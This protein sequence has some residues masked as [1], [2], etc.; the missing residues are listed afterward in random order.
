M[1]HLGLLISALLFGLVHMN[2]KA[3]DFPVFKF[4][5]YTVD[6]GLSV[7]TVTSIIQDSR[8]FM[9][10]A[11]SSGI[12]RYDGVRFRS[13]VPSCE[14]L[15]VERIDIIQSIAEAPD[16]CILAGTDFGLF[17]FN[18]E[19]ESFRRFTMTDGNGTGITSPVYDI[20]AGVEAGKDVIWVATYGQGI[21]CIDAE[22]LSAHD[23][24]SH[25]SIVRYSSQD[26]LPT[27]YVRNIHIDSKGRVWV[28][29]FGDKF[30]YL[31]P[32]RNFMTS[33]SHYAGNS[34]ARYDVMLEDG[35]DVFWLGNYT[36]GLTRFD[37]NTGEFTDFLVPGS[38]GYVSHIR[39]M[40]KYS[41]DLL[42]IASDDGLTYFD[43]RTFSYRT[44]KS[45]RGL[46]Y[47]LNDNYVHSLFIDREK[48][49][50]VGT[51]FGGVS[52][53]PSSAGNFKLFSPYSPESYIEGKIVS[54]VETDSNDNFWI[55]T[56]DA[57]VIFY[58]RKTGYR[59][60]YLPDTGKN[61]ISYHNIHAVCCTGDEVWIGTYSAGVDVLDLKTGKI[62]HYDAD[63]RPG[64]LIHSSVYAL[65]QDSDGTMWVGTS[66]GC[67]TYDGTTDSFVRIEE[68]HGADV[69]CITEDGHGYVL[70]SSYNQGLFRL[71]KN[72]GTW[73]HFTSAGGE[74][75]SDI[76][77]TVSC[78][79]DG[80]L[81]IG[82]GG[83][84]IA[85]YDPSGMKF[86][87]LDADILMDTPVHKIIEYDE[88]IWASTNKGLVKLYRKTLD[89]KL[90]D[91]SDGLQSIQFCPNSGCLTK[92]GVLLFGGINGLN[93]FRPEDLMENTVIPSVY[94]TNI[95]LFNKPLHPGDGSGILDRAPGYVDG[96]TLRHDESVLGIDFV[97]LSFSS[98]DK[99]MYLYMLEGLDDEWTPA[100]HGKSVTYANLAP[101]SY[102]FRVKASNNDML[103]NDSGASLRIRVLPAPWLSP[104]ALTAYAVIFAVSV[105]WAVRM[106]VQRIR[107]MHA[108]SLMRLKVA[109]E[110]ELYESKMSF[111]TDMIHEIRTPLTLIVG[112]LE[113]I[114]KSSRNLTEDNKDDL[115]MIGRNSERLLSLVNQ[116]L[117]YR[118]AE[119]GTMRISFSAMDLNLCVAQ[120]TEPFA[121]SARQRGIDFIVNLPSEHI[122]GEFD[123]DVMSKI[124]SNL[125]SNAMKFTSDKVILDIAS[126][127]AGDDGRRLCIRCD[128]NG[129]GIP[130]A[131]RE[132]IFDSFYQIRSNQPKD[133]VGSGLGLSLVKSIVSCLGG[134]VTVGTAAIGG[135]SFRVSFPF[136]PSSSEV[137]CPSDEDVA[138]GHETAGEETEADGFLPDI[139]TVMIVDDNPDML[140]FLSS[141]LSENYG[142]LSFSN[143]DD[144]L[145]SMEDRLPDLIVSDV[146][147][148]GMDGFLFCRK[149]KNTLGTCH[150]SV[151]LL[152]AKVD[153][154]S[155]I[156]G[157]DCGADIYVEKPF[158]ME[159]LEAQ[160]HSLLLN[161]KKIQESFASRPQSDVIHLASTKADAAF[162]RKVNEYIDENLRETSF[163]A[164]D[165]AVHVGMSRSAF[166]AKL[167]A[168]TGQTPSDYVRIIRLK[169]AVQYFNDG[170][171]RINEVCYMTGF[172]SPS[173]FSKCFY[174]Q[175]GEVPTAYVKRIHKDSSAV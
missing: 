122:F 70:I 25:G 109:K 136:K 2:V 22:C 115:Q 95:S 130:D 34:S 156:E 12:N 124:L 91:V 11:T 101:G 17:I 79:Q 167:R 108:N 143:A 61:S 118:K 6:D 164:G 128:D 174:R 147:M 153:M 69:S 28:L 23:G 119:A 65:F 38:S 149:I 44:L 82:T 88:C 60:H 145:K 126:E 77:T 74:I 87:K 84:G 46:Y 160:I 138:Y 58:D 100:N 54:V 30:G 62:R 158:S 121:S 134:E 103:W 80:R 52:Y 93:A 96:I 105:F 35:N 162:L 16:G 163:T 48:G 55:G 131:E 24:D 89:W 129:G 102:T 5:H 4:R 64:S 72:A 159:F 63:G 15:G 107:T 13:F 31:S 112:P 111:F 41:P 20:C 7:N 117:D 132:K 157:L 50:W 36:R 73:K 51:Y 123:S 173:Y 171:T 42:L 142:V 114:M 150:I 27:D 26:I 127:N 106:S 68:T 56:D 113:H 39:C 154:G 14:E 161:R 78:G 33:F 110:K 98:P 146:M 169:R 76:V 155:K 168:V 3:D 165:I 45:D 47:N 18:P 97:S 8:G 99:N 32:A 37:L 67:C 85:C 10:F 172:N 90:Y 166:F 148:Q 125:L 170:E 1:K 175:F 71:D 104:W 120:I 151:I 116:L 53:S 59:K 86:D 40:C 66:S 49:L 144:A 83:S 92:D 94:I 139:A 141:R 140:S 57:G 43:T 135:A 21:F 133:F 152:T 81:W 75:P 29:T 9:W 137:L 19:Y